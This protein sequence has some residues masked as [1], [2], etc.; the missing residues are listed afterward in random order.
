[1]HKEMAK[2]V[3]FAIFAMWG[4]YDSLGWLVLMGFLANQDILNLNV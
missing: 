1:M 3:S 4:L 2:E